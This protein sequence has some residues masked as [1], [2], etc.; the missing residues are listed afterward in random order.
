[1]GSTTAS[2]HA[3]A[4]VKKLD[5]ERNKST[6]LVLDQVDKNVR[7]LIESYEA[8]ELAPQGAP[9][10]NRVPERSSAGLRKYAT[11]LMRKASRLKFGPKESGWWP[12]VHTASAS[13]A[14]AWYIDW[15]AAAPQ[16]EQAERDAAERERQV[17]EHEAAL[18]PNAKRI[19]E[20]QSIIRDAA[21]GEELL[22]SLHRA[23]VEHEKAQ[24]ARKEL[25]ELK[26]KAENAATALGKKAPV[27]DVSK[28]THA[29]AAESMANI[30]YAG[31]SRN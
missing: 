7:E 14:S 1:M 21:K 9:P 26:I 3:Q 17:H 4:Q 18:K 27:L 23:F 2:K 16:R 8:W 10:I 12:Y 22:A 5:I 11:E 15:N 20:L 30:F 31:M 6:K 19:S 13:L 25:Q 28:S 24:G 29:A